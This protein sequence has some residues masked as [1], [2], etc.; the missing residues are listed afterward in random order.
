VIVLPESSDV[1]CFACD[2]AEMLQSYTANNRRLIEN[3]K[4]YLVLDCDVILTNDHHRVS[5]IQNP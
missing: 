2:E 3:A 5:L 4:Q 1:P